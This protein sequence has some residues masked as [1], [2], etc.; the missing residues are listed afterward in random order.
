MNNFCKHFLMHLWCHQFLLSLQH[1]L[2]KLLGLLFDKTAWFLKLIIR[3]MPPLWILEISLLSF[4][5][6]SIL[7]LD[8]YAGLHMKPKAKLYK[9]DEGCTSYSFTF[10]N[11]V[12]KVTLKSRNDFQTLNFILCMPYN[13]QGRQC[14]MEK[15]LWRE[16]YRISRHFAEMGRWRAHEYSR[17]VV[18]NIC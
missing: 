10:N 9:A 1:D 3:K 2:G 14:W 5:S 16:P 17:L 15:L 13:N 4:D 12:S 18:W 8:I 11:K 7:N 6:N